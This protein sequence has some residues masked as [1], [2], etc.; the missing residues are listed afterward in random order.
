MIIASK[1]PEIDGLLMSG[2]SATMTGYSCCGVSLMQF[3]GV[4]G[5]WLDFEVK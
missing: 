1:R 5:L 3:A 4:A 2:Y